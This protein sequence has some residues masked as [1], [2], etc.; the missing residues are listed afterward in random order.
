MGPT[1]LLDFKNIKPAPKQISLMGLYNVLI[2]CPL[3]CTLRCI[4]YHPNFQDEDIS[5]REAVLMSRT[6]L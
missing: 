3:A 5:R 6:L 2:V 4:T 1:E